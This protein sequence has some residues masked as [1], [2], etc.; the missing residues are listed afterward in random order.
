MSSLKSRLHILEKSR[1]AQCGPGFLAVVCKDEN[2][3]YRTMDGKPMTAEEVA[4]LGACI[5]VDFI[6]VRNIHT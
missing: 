2:G 3:D 6:G 1:A 5:V 4:G